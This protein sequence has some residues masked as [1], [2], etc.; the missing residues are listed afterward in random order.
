MNIE[1]NMNMQEL[2]EEDYTKVYGGNGATCIFEDEVL[3]VLPELP[4]PPSGHEIDI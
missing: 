4:I 1:Q 3:K 2:R